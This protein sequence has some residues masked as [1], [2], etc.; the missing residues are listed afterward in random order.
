MQIF[1]DQ[2]HTDMTREPTSLTTAW[3]P[4]RW[5]DWFFAAALVAGVFLVY[6]PAWR[7]G[8][9]MDDDTHVTCPEL[10]SW[11]GL[12]RIWLD[13]G[14]TTQYY[15]L[16]HSVFWF[17]HRLWGDATLGYHLLNILLHAVAALMV[18]GILRRLAVPGA[19]LAAAIFALHP[20]QV[21]SVAW[22]SELKN[23]LSAVFYLGAMLSY[24]KFDHTRSK[25]RYGL[26]LLLF[27]LALL[28]K[29]VTATLP[30][31][32]L[33][34]FWWQRGRL[35]W[36]KD[37]APLLP[38]FALGAAAGVFTAWVERK[39]IG[40][41]GE[42]FTFSLLERGLIAGRAIWFYLG[43]LFWP[44]DLV[45]VYPRWQVSQGA[46]WQY[47]FPL[48]T[49]ALLL[50]LWKLRRRTRAPL[51]AALF[52][53]GTLFPVLGFLNVYPFIYSFVAD[54]YQYLASL[55]AITLA[56]AGLTLALRRWNDWRQPAGQGFCLLLVGTL[57]ILSWRQS[58]MYADAETLYRTT[59]DRN[60]EC[61]LAHNNLG[62]ELADRGQ[63]DEAIAHFKRALEIKP[64]YE[65]AQNNLGL[66]SAGR[67][68]HRAARIYTL[69]QLHNNLGLSLAGRGKFDEAI[70]QYKQ[71]LEIKPDYAEAHNNLGAALAGSGQ[72]NEAIAHYQK[73]LEID[74]NFVGAH[75]NLGNLLAG[76][77]EIDEAVAHYQR[78]LEIKPDYAEAHND[79]GAAL[80][81][82]GQFDEALAHYQQ[83]LKIKPGYAEA[84]SNLANILASR[85]QFDEAIAH[86][87]K[88]LEI[89]PHFAAAH[90]NL[91]NVLA[92]RGQF[93]EAV[94]HYQKALKIKPDHAEA[95]KNLRS[96][97]ALQE[98]IRTVL[99]QR[100][101]SIRLHPDDLVTLQETAWVLATNPDAS[102]R[103]GAE[104]VELA[105]RGAKLA[106]GSN[107]QVLDTLAAAYAEAGRFAEAV[108][109][110]QQAL[111]QA[112]SGNDTALAGAVRDRIRLYQA[113]SPYREAR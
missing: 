50:A 96:V 89:D 16:L 6:Q 3:P 12:Q 45:F 78:A 106:G 26:A 17:E 108:E 49:A 24:L 101:E 22:V 62:W 38:F 98:K 113:G 91:A 53:V 110:A 11:Q 92:S 69:D 70:A 23:T 77:G 90:N 46:W 42:A 105:Q 1:A 94:G 27:V 63:V 39:L 83:A 52:F 14:A 112:S 19:Y 13:V 4:L 33:V 82:R 18:A 2:D 15:P 43:N 88:A 41:E 35:K 29:T 65:L 7:G 32:V 58:R 34:I 28:S 97:L 44:A 111:Q 93:D 107:P 20:V 80:A 10:R 51:A 31:A 40:A 60:P 9:V 109:T 54:H 81:G 55:G 79:L 8:F 48:A 86:Y 21:E 75:N 72:L 87:Q 68:Q 56:S 102:V 36:K 47:L 104:A 59:I 71:A 66:F 95:Q 64:D 67:G 61:W 25:W 76:C 74:P 84:H 73:A 85:G 30:A 100:R 57:A 99:A 37:V 5:T 103:N